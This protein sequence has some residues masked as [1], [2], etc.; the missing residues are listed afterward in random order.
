M[1]APRGISFT[2][3]RI[4]RMPSVQPEPHYW[5]FGCGR[6]TLMEALTE[7]DPKELTRKNLTRKN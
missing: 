6:A 7:S 1:K 5:P 2:I 4:N 3:Y